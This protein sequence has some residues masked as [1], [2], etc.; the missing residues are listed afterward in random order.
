LHGGPYNRSNGE[1][2]V[3]AQLLV[4]RGYIVFEPNFRAS[5]GLGVRYL[6]AAKGNF[7]RHGVLDDIISGLDHLIANGIG[8]SDQQAV[9][10]HSFGGY[11]SLLAVTHHPDRF[12]FAVPLAAPVDFAWTMAEIAVEGGSALSADGPPIEIVLTGHGVP[13]RDPAWHERM[14]RDAPLAHA[15]KLR[16]PVYL[17]AGARDDRVAVESLVRYVAD[18]SA[19]SRPVLLI[20]PDAGHSPRDRS[21]REALAWLIEASA[22]AHF[23]GGVS[24]PSSSLKRFLQKNLRAG[25]TERLLK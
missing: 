25:P 19:A 9:I 20:D 1:Y 11:A 12:A 18:A 3:A 21:N 14:H 6:T 24:P 13:Y 7:G 22:N 23:G 2:D 5:T 8:D 17:W 16:T 15:A 4:N 10:G